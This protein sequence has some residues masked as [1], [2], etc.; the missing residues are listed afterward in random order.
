MRSLVPWVRQELP[1]AVRRLGETCEG[2]VEAVPPL[3]IEKDKAK[4]LSNYKEV[5]TPANCKNSVATTGMY[6]AGGSLLWLD[7]GFQGE[8]VS[9]LH[10]EPQWPVLVQYQEQF[11]SREACSQAEEGEQASGLG[12]LVFPMTLE[13]YEADLARDW[14]QMPRHLSL[15]AGQPM[16]L[17]WYLAAARALQ[18][19]DD[20][21][22][23]QLWQAALTCTIRVT[24]TDSVGKLALSAVAASEKYVKFAEMTDT[25]FHWATKVQSIIVDFDAK[26]RQSGPLATKQLSDMGVRYRGA[27]VN[28]HHFY[29][30]GH[31][32]ELFDDH[33]FD[34]LRAIENEFGRRVL[35]VDYTKLKAF[36]EAVKRTA[37]GVS[38]PNK[39]KEVPAPTHTHTPRPPAPRT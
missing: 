5:W 19:S 8:H 22:L 35:S 10:Q 18:Q 12:R 30:V 20:T 4:T 31:V 38:A 28:K 27:L 39:L 36:L 17:A 21:L 26:T 16:L 6:E 29:S 25:F 24:A 7:P 11:F 32:H 15:L 9:M 23:L 14:A 37:P 33:T 1:A 34:V 13:A 2:G 3:K